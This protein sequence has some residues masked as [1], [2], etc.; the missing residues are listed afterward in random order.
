M[1]FVVNKLCVCFEMT[2]GGTESIMMACKAYRDYAYHEKG[3]KKAEIILPTTAH[4][5]F[6]KAAQYFSMHIT[7][8]LVDEKTKAVDI[9]AMEKAI[10]NKTVMVNMSRLF[11]ILVAYVH[12]CVSVSSLVYVL[13]S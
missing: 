3:I 8:I 4:P 9:R 10:S 13:L 7:H 6:D 11:V 1:Y 12:M 2:T 5:A